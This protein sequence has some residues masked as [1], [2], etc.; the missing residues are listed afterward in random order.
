L[1]TC[2]ISVVVGTCCT[3]LIIR[4]ANANVISLFQSITKLLTGTVSDVM[5]DETVSEVSEQ[6]PSQAIMRSFAWQ[7]CRHSCVTSF[8]AV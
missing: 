2:E 5:Q 7:C 6:H 8:V 4:R 3:L 1:G